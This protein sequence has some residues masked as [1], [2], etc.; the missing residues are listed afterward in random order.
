MTDYFD[1]ARYENQTTIPL[2]TFDGEENKKFWMNAMKPSKLEKEVVDKIKQKIKIFEF[3]IAF[4]AIISILLSQFEYEL[5]YYPKM[6]KP[7]C[8]NPERIKEYKGQPARIV[9]SILCLLMALLTINNSLLFYKQKK[10][11]KKII[12]SKIIF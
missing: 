1:D 10:E 11:E 7:T 8:K 9:V 6:Y 4:L 5:E 12:T 2:D 3:L